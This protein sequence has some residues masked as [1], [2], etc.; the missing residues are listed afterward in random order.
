[1]EPA[2]RAPSDSLSAAE[3]AGQ[4]LIAGYDGVDPPR[5]LRRM[6][7]RG[8][9]A[10]VI[11][12]A[13][14]VGGRT[15]TRRA[16]GSLQRVNRRSSPGTPL[17][18]MVDQEGGL[19]ER[20]PGPPSASAE[21]MGERSRRFA[22]RQGRATA[23]NLTR[24]GINVDL[25]PVL[26]VARRG[27]AIAGEDR[28][29]GRTPEP[30]ALARGERVRARACSAA[31]SLRPRSTSPGSARPG[32]TPMTPPSGSRSPGA[33]CGRRRA[34]VP[35][36]AER[37][38]R[39]GD[40][41]ARDLHRLRQ[42]TRLA[43]PEDRHRRAASPARLRGGHDH[44]LPR[45]RADHGVR[46]P[47]PGRARGAPTPAPTCCST[48]VG[49]PPRRSGKTLRRKLLR[50]QARPLRVRGGGRPGAGAAARSLAG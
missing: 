20:V 8:E 16:I 17:L 13:D 24:Y 42:P 12:F 37:D 46:G 33:A 45:R 4:R 27:S 44:R 18:V 2:A 50:R 23:R 41:R 32:S 29:F 14:N 38:G 28:S 36:F 5:G 34:P 10:G 35:A 3:L 49:R 9:L 26:D 6:I 43:Q 25:A 1:M 21:E 15:R 30:G 19:V 39:A 48:G 7:G 31:A 22:C 40:A 11:L 47:Q